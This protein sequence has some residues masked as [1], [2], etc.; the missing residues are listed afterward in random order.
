MISAEEN[1]RPERS[2]R[3]RFKYSSVHEL[4][5]VNTLP[6]YDLGAVN[7]CI[8]RFKYSSTIGPSLGWRHA[9]L[10]RWTTFSGSGSFADCDRDPA[11]LRL[12]HWTDILYVD[13]GSVLAVW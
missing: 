13:L 8:L 12:W 11:L 10:L 9:L 1:S 3:L 5:A 6:V 2:G 4:N 7:D